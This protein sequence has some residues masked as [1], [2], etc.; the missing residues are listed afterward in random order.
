M[1]EKQKNVGGHV[2]IMAGY[3]AIEPA[4]ENFGRLAQLV[5]DKKIKS[6]GMIL[7]ERDKEGQ[8]SIAA[9]VD[10]Q[11]RAGAGWTGGVGLIVGLVSPPLLVSVGTGAATGGLIG[12]FTKRKVESGIES[13]LGDKLKPGTAAVIAIVDGA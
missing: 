8:V 9:T 13:G 11:G 6:E 4:E 1:N 7:V 2:V 5:K 10:R 3:Q 12:K